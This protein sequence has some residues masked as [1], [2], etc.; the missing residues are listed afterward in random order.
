L[1]SGFVLFAALGVLAAGGELIALLDHDID[2]EVIVL[3]R[4]GGVD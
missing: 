3:G 1:N 2:L 4:G